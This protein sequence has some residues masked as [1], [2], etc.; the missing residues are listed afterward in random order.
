MKTYKYTE[1]GL[2]NV[3]IRGVAFV[4]DDAGDEVVCIPNI[5]GLHRAIAY[6]IVT[7]RAAMAGKELRFLRT[8]MGMTQAELAELIHREPLAISR[9]E[10]E[11]VPIDTNAE[12]LIRLHAAETLGLDLEATVKEVSGWSI[13]RAQEVPIE[14]DGSDPGNY[15]PARQAA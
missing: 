11:E 13:P 8:E 4:K 1:C 7:R 6:G 3:I 2:D 10:R 15:H 9:W 12:T 14:I 5:N